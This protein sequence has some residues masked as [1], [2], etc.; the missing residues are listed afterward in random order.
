LIR[1]VYGRCNQEKLSSIDDLVTKYKGRLKA[2]YLQVCEKYG[3]EPKE[4]KA[5]SDKESAKVKEDSA[6]SKS[7]QPGKSA[8]AAEH[9]D[10]SSAKSAGSKSRHEDSVS[11]SVEDVVRQK[12]QQPELKEKLLAT[13]SRYIMEGNTWGD[14]LW[15]EAVYQG[16]LFG[17]N[18]LGKI[19]L[20]IRSELFQ[21]E[22]ARQIGW[23]RTEQEP[24]DE[25]AVRMQDGRAG[26]ASATDEA[27]DVADGW[28][29]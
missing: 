15:G 18:E 1:G 2:V 8:A 13:G 12:F 26:L 17:Y 10:A 3:E 22:L 23:R 7:P 21:S 11:A 19:I 25:G 9:R 29:S 28:D 16:E 6:R 5:L 20:T 14:C 4:P 24:W 27:R